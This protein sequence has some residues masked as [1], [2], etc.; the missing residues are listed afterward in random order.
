VSAG[1]E[2]TTDYAPF[3]DYDGDMACH[4]NT[5]HCRRVIGGSDWRRS[6]LQRRYHGY[7]SWYLQE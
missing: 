4:C 6:E 7:F 2:L 3:D 5:A 1:E